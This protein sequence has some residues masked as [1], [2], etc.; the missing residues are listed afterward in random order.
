MKKQVCIVV[1]PQVDV[2]AMSWEHTFKFEG[3]KAS[4]G[5]EDRLKAYKLGLG[6]N[7]HFA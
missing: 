5:Q 2:K 1:A 4:N 6:L 7:R 3:M